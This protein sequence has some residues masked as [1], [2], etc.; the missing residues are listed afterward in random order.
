MKNKAVALF[1]CAEAQEALDLASMV[2][3]CGS[4]Y[5]FFGSLN[6]IYVACILH[7]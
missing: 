1:V 5:V 2:M 6:Y 7:L 4:N 3:V